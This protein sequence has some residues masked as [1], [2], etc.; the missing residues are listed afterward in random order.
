MKKVP[1][2]TKQNQRQW[3]LSIKHWVISSTI[4]K[5]IDVDSDYDPNDLP[6]LDNH[7]TYHTH[8]SGN[9]FTSG[10]HIITP[11]CASY[12]TH[13]QYW[14]HHPRLSP[15]EKQD[16]CISRY[17]QKIVNGT[18]QEG[19]RNYSFTVTYNPNPRPVIPT[20][21]TTSILQPLF[22]W[23]RIVC[24]STPHTWLPINYETWF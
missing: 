4:P 16:Q 7:L 22:I 24:Q 18:H 17:I 13:T 3:S 9:W 21:P 5:L 11:A 10:H 23:P 1:E 20:W 19:T 8:C 14:P 12:H 2:G 15:Q 6:S